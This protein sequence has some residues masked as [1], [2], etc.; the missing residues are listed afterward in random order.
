MNIVSWFSL[1]HSISNV[2]ASRILFRWKEDRLYSAWNRVISRWSPISIPIL[3]TRADEINYAHA[4]SSAPSFERKSRS[5]EEM[6]LPFLADASRR[7]YV[8]GAPSVYTQQHRISRILSWYSEKQGPVERR[9]IRTSGLIK[10]Y[11]NDNAVSRKSFGRTMG[12]IMAG[13]TRPFPVNANPQA[14]HCALRSLYPRPSCPSRTRERDA[15]HPANLL[16]GRR[17]SEAGDAIEYNLF[18]L[19]IVPIN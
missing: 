10:R 17:E 12:C 9:E 13:M 3:A 4:V 1:I 2:S 15:R 11:R 8:Y 14:S 7:A 19:A 5:G 18:R 16:L 6:Q